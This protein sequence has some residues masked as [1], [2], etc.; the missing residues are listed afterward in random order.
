M[1]NNN[2]SQTQYPAG[3]GQGIIAIGST[4]VN[5][6]IAGSS[7]TGNHID[8]SA[9]GVNI[10]S[11]YRNPDYAYNSG[12]SMA[13]PHVS[14]LASLLKGYNSNLYN[15]DIEHIIQLSADDKGDP[16][17]DQYYG[18][19]RINAKTA[20][21]L[22][23]SP[24]VLQQSTTTGGTDIG[25]T[26]YYT[27]VIYGA[28]GLATGVY[29]VKR[30]EIRKTVSYTSKQ[31][32]N[33]WGRG[34]ATNGWSLESPNFAMG[35]CDVVP[36]TVTSTSATLRTY[37]YQV[38]SVSGSYLGYYPTTASNVTFAYTVHGTPTPLAASISGPSLLNPG[39]NGTWTANVTGGTPPYHYQ[40]AYYYYCNEEDVANE[41]EPDAP[42]CGY[43]WNIGSDSPQITRYDY[44]SFRLR[45]IVTD[46]ASGNVTAYK[47]VTVSGNLNKE[48]IYAGEIPKAYSLE[49][50]YPNPFNPSTQINYALPSAAKVNIKVYDLLGR[51]V[52]ELVNEQKEAGIYTVRFDASDLSSGIY[53]YGLLLKKE[54]KYCSQNQ[55]E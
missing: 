7:N 17:W 15:D 1:G 5:D 42:P 6:V 30:H 8:V 55:N 23:R 27:T 28:P 48:N 43:W 14:G 2:G 41:L 44:Q 18:Y 54:K 22:L 33:V 39:Q 11:T 19:G 37:I 50:N 26:D 46:A 38:W 32:V 24:Y 12:T 29:I 36:G 47:Y 3:F 45:C 53:L 9:P 16:G 20:I 21:D 25:S 31:N 51:E 49:Q 10:Y 52:R 40:W 13:A 35:W 34:V 4:D